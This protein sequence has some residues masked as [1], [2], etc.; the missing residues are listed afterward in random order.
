MLRNMLGVI[1]GYIVMA[2]LVALLLAAA[3]LRMGTEGAF[4]EGSYEVTTAWLMTSFALGLV[5]AVI[6]GL[7]CAFI[8]RRGSTAP[9]GLAVLVIV[10]GIASAGF[11]LA[12]PAS[13]QPRTRG[14]EVDSYEA[15]MNAEQP[16]IALLANPIIGAA[17]VLIGAWLTKRGKAA[18]ENPEAVDF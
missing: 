15:M 7:A 6:G 11:H 9:I 10:L 4:E 3:Y 16:A 17:G 13:E 2:I 5:A 18:P 8:A 1:G 12:G 14:P